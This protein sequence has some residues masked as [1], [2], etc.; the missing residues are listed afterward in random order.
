[1]ARTPEQREFAH[2]RFDELRDDLNRRE[3][4]NTEAYDKAI[5]AVSSAFLGVSVAGFKILVQPSDAHHLWMML[6]SWSLLALVIPVSLFSFI[7]SNRGIA[8]LRDASRR[9]YIDEIEEALQAPNGYVKIN[10]GMNIAAG[11]GLTLAVLLAVGFI[12]I[13]V[14]EQA[15]T[16]STKSDVTRTGDTRRSANVPTMEPVPQRPSP[17]GS[18]NIPTLESIPAP[19]PT[20]PSE[21]K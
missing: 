6:T 10:K 12:I 4:S 7:V 17:G 19:K 18:T 11:I 16:M 21:T 9:Y 15:N 2:R 3:L 14:N 8:V 20:P 5:F 1:M 13:N